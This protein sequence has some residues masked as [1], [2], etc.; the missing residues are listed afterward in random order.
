MEPKN[1]MIAKTSRYIGGAAAKF[2]AATI[3]LSVAASSRDSCDELPVLCLVFPG[4]LDG[5]ALRC[6][7]VVALAGRKGMVIASFEA[8]NKLRYINPEAENDE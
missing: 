4:V 1:G 8:M 7:A 2:L 3:F 5:K 6:S